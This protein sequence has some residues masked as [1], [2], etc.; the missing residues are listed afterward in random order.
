MF[1]TNT[2]W[3]EVERFLWV[4]RGC[5]RECR[6]CSQVQPLQQEKCDHSDDHVEKFLKK[7]GKQIGGD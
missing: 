5:S 2:K 1:Q 6:V 3:V 7:Y 4:C